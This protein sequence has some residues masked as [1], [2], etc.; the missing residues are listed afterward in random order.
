MAEPTARQPLLIHRDHR[1]TFEDN[2]Y[3]Y[4]V[5]SR[6]SKGVSIGLNLNPDKICNFDCV[7]C[8]VDR[9]TPA[10]VRDVDVPQLLAEL[11]EMLDL[12]V[13]GE[14]FELERFRG[15]PAGLRR[16]NDLAFSG[17]GEPTTCPEFPEIVRA[18]AGIKQQRGLSGVKMVLITNAT[19]L[20]HPPVQEGLAILDA[21]QGEIWAKLEAGTDAY[22]HAIERTTIPLARVL[23]NITA[24]AKVRPLV[25]QSMFLRMNGQPPSAAELDAFCDRLN[26]ITAA[27]GKLTLVQVYTVARVPAEAFVTPLSN[28]EVDSIVALVKRRT[29]IGAE[30]FYGPN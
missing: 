17:D 27:G 9:K 28:A 2:R 24:A 19:R 10:D 8:Q 15:T 25:I 20:Q 7:Y 6:R 26:D 21:N 29:G 5:V 11:E 30:A 18:V 16:L 13:S 12:V 3:V 4:A 22:Y 1:R 14:L 23:E